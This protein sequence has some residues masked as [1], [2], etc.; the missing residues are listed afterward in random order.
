MT[1]NLSL[2]ECVNC[3]NRWVG[4]SECAEC[5]RE[6]HPVK[7]QYGWFWNETLGKYEMVKLE[8]KHD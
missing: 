8:D 5:Y 1:E 2:R 7:E 6:K 3:G 4:E